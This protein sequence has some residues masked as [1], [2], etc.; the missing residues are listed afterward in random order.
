MFG[1]IPV[2]KRR[3]FR[4]PEA[5]ECCWIQF[6]SKTWALWQGN[7]PVPNSQWRD[8]QVIDQ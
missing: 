7:L 1:V 6:D 2:G 8:E 4:H 5:F 3:A